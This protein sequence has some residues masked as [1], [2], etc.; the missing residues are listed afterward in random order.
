MTPKQIF[1]LKHL[2]KGDSTTFEASRSAQGAGI[3]KARCELE[4]ADAPF[5]ELRKMGYA[6]RT[7]KLGTF[8][9]S[10]HTIT[11]DGRAAIPNNP[12]HSAG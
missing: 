8:G 11:A 1:C 4:W 6:K 5:R 12:P 2:S 7:G 9:R 10:I 3:N